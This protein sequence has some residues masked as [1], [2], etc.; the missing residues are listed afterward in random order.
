MIFYIQPQHPLYQNISLLILNYVIIKKI[1]KVL[2]FIMMVLW[3][4]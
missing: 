4:F 3:E 2:L 1:I